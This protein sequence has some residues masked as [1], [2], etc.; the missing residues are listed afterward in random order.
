MKRID[1]SAFKYEDPEGRKQQKRQKVAPVKP[2]REQSETVENVPEVPAQPNESSTQVLQWPGPLKPLL[3]PGLRYVFVGFNPGVESAKQGHHYAHHSN[4]FWKLLHWSG[5]TPRKLACQ[6]DR[7]MPKNY[8][9]GFTDLV[10]RS[11]KGIQQLTKQ[12][13]ADGVN[14]LDDR[15]GAV[16][17]KVVCFVGKGIW[18]TVAKARGWDRKQFRYGLDENHKFGHGHSL[19]C[20]VPSTSGLTS[21]SIEK[22]LGWWNEVASLLPDHEEPS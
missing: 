21:I 20:C 5:L 3:T 14:S 13:M 11:T 12:E 19:L 10:A 7:T 22:Q 6:E 18:E 16:Q 17:P 1:F 8:G 9:I 15:I 2:K 4:R